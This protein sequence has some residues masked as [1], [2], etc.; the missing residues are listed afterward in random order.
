MIDVP[1]N[2][3]VIGLL[4]P[5]ISFLGRNFWSLCYSQIVIIITRM[6]TMTIVMMM[7]IGGSQPI[8]RDKVKSTTAGNLAKEGN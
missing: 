7:T 3:K 2:A 4:L 6:M 1:L 5:I 8:P